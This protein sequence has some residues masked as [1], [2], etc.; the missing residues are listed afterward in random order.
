MIFFSSVKDF[1][2][3]EGFGALPVNVGAVYGGAGGAIDHGFR[4]SVYLARGNW[5]WDA[6]LVWVT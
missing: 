1:S 6:A 3:D 5:A 2:V 4:L